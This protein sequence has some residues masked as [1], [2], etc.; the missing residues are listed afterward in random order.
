ME[1]IVVK[2]HDGKELIVQKGL[3]PKGYV[4]LKDYKEPKKTKKE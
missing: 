1:R 3:I 2:N 4:F